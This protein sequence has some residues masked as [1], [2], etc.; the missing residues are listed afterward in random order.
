MVTLFVGA[1]VDA[2]AATGDEGAMAA[3]SIEQVLA[4]E[5]EAIQGTK[6]LA[7]ALLKDLVAAPGADAKKANADEPYA[8][9]AKVARYRMDADQRSGEDLPVEEVKDRKAF[10]RA[11]NK[12][13]RAAPCCSGG[14]I[15]SA[16]FCLGVISGVG[17][18]RRRRRGAC[19]GKRRAPARQSEA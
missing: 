7:D 14:G 9:D 18:V 5:A 11:L 12:L 4:E 15:R 10:Y 1:A 2:T 19:T 16:T 3:L 13:N 17:R 6:G 8:K